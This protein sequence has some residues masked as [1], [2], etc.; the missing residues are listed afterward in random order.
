[1]FYSRL[2]EKNVLFFINEMLDEKDDTFLQVKNSHPLLEDN[3]AY[4]VNNYYYNPDD[5]WWHDD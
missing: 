1:M 3:L 5:Y 2:K 4:D